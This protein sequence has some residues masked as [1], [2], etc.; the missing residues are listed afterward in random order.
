[1]PAERL[2]SDGSCGHAGERFLKPLLRVHGPAPIDGREVSGSVR[3][4]VGVSVRVRVGVDICWLSAPRLQSQARKASKK[5]PSI[6][7]W[8]LSVALDERLMLLFP[9]PG[10]HLI[11]T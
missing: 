5:A 9:L 2:P 10:V 6:S 1:M 3:V 8:R 7:V 4:S 11:L